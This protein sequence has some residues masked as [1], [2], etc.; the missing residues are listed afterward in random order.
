[1]P[2]PHRPLNEILGDER[3]S[4]LLA[5]AFGSLLFGQSLAKYSRDDL[6]VALVMNE[7]VYRRYWRRSHAD[8]RRRELAMFHGCRGQANEVSASAHTRSVHVCMAAR[9]C[10]RRLRLPKAQQLAEEVLQ[11]RRARCRVELAVARSGPLSQRLR[12]G[13]RGVGAG[14]SRRGSSAWRTAL[15]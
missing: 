6:L 3:H 12:S 7:E 4:E 14:L 8:S 10:P 15:R 1:M 5:T 2:V 9:A 11:L 13:R